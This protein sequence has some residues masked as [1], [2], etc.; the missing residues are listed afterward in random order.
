ANARETIRD[1][2]ASLSNRL[3]KY[4][5]LMSYQIQAD[6]L[7]RTTTRKIKRLE[8]KKL[9]ESGHLTSSETNVATA[10]PG[11][12]DKA[13]LESA[14]GQEVLHCLRENYRRDTPV[15][16]N[17]NLE[18]DL[19]FDSM[20]RVEFIADL[21]QRLNLKLPEDFGAEIFTLRDLILRLEQEAGVAPRAGA[22]VRQSWKKILEAEPQEQEKQ[23]PY[24]SGTAMSLAKYA[25][26]RAIYYLFFRTL[27]RMETRGLENLPLKGPYLVCPNHQSYLDPLVLASVLPFSVFRRMFFVGYSLFFTS[28]IMKLVARLTNIVPVDPDA[29]LLHAMKAGAAGL[30]DGYILCIFPEGGRSFDGTLQPFKK[31]AAILSRELSAPVI[32]TAIG[33]TY[34]VW[35]R[36]S[37]R[38][39]PHKV[40]ITF[41]KPIMP[42]ETGDADP[43]RSDTDRLW[44]AIAGLM[45]KQDKD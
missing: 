18:L 40:T 13:L 44:N 36:D 34:E 3:P 9:V 45:Q 11:P 20:E 21:E 19:G 2:I 26:S 35:P 5:R 8:L 39:R 16:P 12:E 31:G 7:M 4:K 33:G 1:E 28:R 10:E 29:H 38:I 22:A 42:E 41:G 43:Y 32:P 14:I 27:L 17:M 15:T 23:F 25:C 37:I 24:V 30:R 6:P